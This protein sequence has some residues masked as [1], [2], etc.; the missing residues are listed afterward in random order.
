MY[1]LADLGAGTDGGPGVYHGALVDIGADIHIGRHQ[2]DVARDVGAAACNR[3]WHNAVAAG[4][5]VRFAEV[6]EL[7]GNFVIELHG[8]LSHEAVVIQAE[9]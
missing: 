6:T 2:D 1:V 8:L 9:G 7:E 5:E 4:F 3:G